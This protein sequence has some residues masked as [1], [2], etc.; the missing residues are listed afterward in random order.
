MFCSPE[1]PSASEDTLW[2]ATRS[3]ARSLGRAQA[4]RRNHL[5]DLDGRQPLATH[6]LCRFERGQGG[7]ASTAGAQASLLA[8]FREEYWVKRRHKKY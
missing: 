1:G 4:C 2:L 6:G 7:G 5:F 8:Y 3:A